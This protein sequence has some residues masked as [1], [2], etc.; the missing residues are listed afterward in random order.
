MRFLPT[1]SPVTWAA[2]VPASCNERDVET[3]LNEALRPLNETS[4][5]ILRVMVQPGA[6]ITRSDV[7][8]D[9]AA[10][11]TAGFLVFILLLAV[12]GTLRRVVLA[13]SFPKNMRALLDT[14]VPEDELSCVH[15]LR[16]LASLFIY[17]IHR[18]VFAMFYP[19]TN[20]TQVAELLEG[21]WTMVFRA[22]WNWVD[23]FVVLS[24]LLTSFY[25]VK[26]LQ[27]GKSINIPRM[28]LQRYIN[29]LANINQVYDAT[30]KAGSGLLN[31]NTVLLGD[32]DQCLSAQDG[33]VRG[34]YCL[35]TVYAEPAMSTS[36]PSSTRRAAVHR[37][38]DMMQ[39]HNAMSNS[40]SDYSPVT[41]AA[42]V[43]ASCNERDVETSLNEALRPLN[44]TSGVILRVMVQPGACITRSDVPVDTA[45]VATANFCTLRRVVLAF[46]FPKNMRALLDTS[47]PEDELSCV[48]GLRALASLFIYLIHRSVFAM[49]Y[50]FTNRTQVAELLEGDWTM[51]FR[52]F[53]NWVDSFVVLSGLLTSFYAVKKLQE[54]KS[55][56]IPR[57]YLQ[58]YIKFT[59]MLWVLS[60][61][62]QNLMEHMISAPQRIRIVDHYIQNC[63]R[64]LLP[65]VTYTNTFEGFE[66]MAL[67]PLNETSGVILRV[68]VQP[69][70]CITR[71][72]VPVD[73]AACYPPSHQLAT[74]MHMYL[75]SPFMILALWKYPRRGP[76]ALGGLLALLAALKYYEVFTYGLGSFIFYGISV[77][78]M[79]I[80]ANHIYINAIHRLTP[81]IFGL[82]LGYLLRVKA[83]KCT[84]SRVQ[85]A[86]GSAIA[87]AGAAYSFYGVAHVARRGYQ[88][89]ARE[90][91]AFAVVQPILWSF[92]LCWLIFC[93]AT[94]QAP[95]TLRRV[96][97]AFSFPKNMRALLDTSVPE[98][99]LSCVH[100]LRALAS[101]FIYL[102]HPWLRRGLSWKGFVVF[103]RLSYAVYLVQIFVIA[104][105]VGNSMTAEHFRFTKMLDLN[106]IT[107]VMVISLLCTLLLL[108]PL[109]DLWNIV[110]GTYK[111]SSQKVEPEQKKTTAPQ[112]KPAFTKTDSWRL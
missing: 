51:V 86:A 20:R 58:R 104:V 92:A 69:G 94:G 111:V 27:E 60:L 26:K 36:R 70:A 7:P 106:E 38:L 40:Y 45:A 41:W 64:G 91:A 10:V 5:V 107:V 6:C 98:D 47:V 65:V 21:D 81:Y 57:M 93:C 68:M 77:K 82:G 62:L 4:G 59:P 29:D 85:M 71:S 24:G 53:W 50:P 56:N 73:T 54:G 31:G 100:G 30:A 79:V 88:Y 44:E 25:A 66:N 97:L 72:D 108:L 28:Y 103:S 12:I 78:E 105:N 55:I 11:A 39:S 101:L 34:Q 37:A 9:T 109:Q 87:L 67:R 1:F 84:I 75:L 63:K 35:S 15:G 61:T 95:G 3:S 8:V 23:S 2:C 46:S 49:F 102:I 52:A 112:V 19:F 14:S 17:L 18:S 99:E 43:P 110:A 33:E 13:F 96:F 22:F 76:L 89:D 32:L 80:S 42:C 83:G 48:H 74:D 90:A 16:A